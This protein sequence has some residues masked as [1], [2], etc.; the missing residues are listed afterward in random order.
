MD[1][2]FHSHTRHLSSTIHG[3][4][5]NKYDDYYSCVGSLKR[6]R[7]IFRHLQNQRFASK[8]I[9]TA[10]NSQ[11]NNGHTYRHIYPMTSV[12]FLPKCHDAKVICADMKGGLYMY[13]PTDSVVQ[14]EHMFNSGS[15]E[16]IN[17]MLVNDRNECC[18]AGNDC[19][20]R[21]FDLERKQQKLSFHSHASYVT[22]VKYENS[23]YLTSSL[24]GACSIWHACLTR[25]VF[26]LNVEASNVHSC[27]FVPNTPY[28]IITA[29]EKYENG[30]S[31]SHVKLWDIRYHPTYVTHILKSEH[32]HQF[33]SI[34]DKDPIDTASYA[35]DSEG[36]EDECSWG[37]GWSQGWGSQRASKP[38]RPK[39]EQ[40]SFVPSSFTSTEAYVFNKTLGRYQRNIQDHDVT[41][42][43]YH[44]CCTPTA[45]LTSS[46]DS[47]HK[48]WSLSNQ[49]PL[50]SFDGCKK[51]DF[52]SPAP[53]FIQSYD[54]IVCGDQTGNIYI[55][56]TYR[57]SNE[58]TS[59]HA[60]KTRVLNNPISAIAANELGDFIAACDDHGNISLISLTDGDT[61]E[62]L[63][64]SE[65]DPD[66]PESSL[67]LLDSSQYS[68]SQ[69]LKGMDSDSAVCQ[70]TISGLSKRITLNQGPEPISKRNSET[71]MRSRKDLATSRRRRVRSRVIVEQ[72]DTGNDSD[73]D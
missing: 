68:S 29:S 16:S 46:M 22:D 2:L 35:S 57:T 50:A 45:V 5:A 32:K 1:F 7:Y 56:N 53:V 61:F 44:V 54:Q 31:T 3:R 17:R 15:S 41:K 11:K 65:S 62:D 64:T 70:I 23:L 9:S 49:H 60:Y 38:P 48:L 24:D 20:L 18:I 10:T 47:S 12:S 43:I 25:P 72:H 13:Q 63:D 73:N 39:M 4:T 51:S 69:D 27:S 14:F 30:S 21:V 58:Y 26:S 33:S 59:N 34:W 37:S 67:P 19:M 42:R 71:V 8:S 6:K 40:A 55:W 52:T 28:Q 36:E 66:L